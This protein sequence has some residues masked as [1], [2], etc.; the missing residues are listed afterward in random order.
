MFYVDIFIHKC[1]FNLFCSN[2]ITQCIHTGDL[3]WLLNTPPGCPH[4]LHIRAD[5]FL[6][7]RLRHIGLGGTCHNLFNEAFRLLPDLCHRANNMQRSKRNMK[8]WL[9]FVRRQLLGRGP[10]WLSPI[11]WQLAVTWGVGAMS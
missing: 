6:F 1:L 11:R 8:T 10:F 5:S 7:I 2:G 4:F 3:P 9:G